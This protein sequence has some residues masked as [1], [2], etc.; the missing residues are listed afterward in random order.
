MRL[1]RFKDDEF[2]VTTVTT[3]EEVKQVLNAGF[4]Y[5]TQKDGVM[6]LNPPKDLVK[7]SGILNAKL[8]MISF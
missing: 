3:L 7:K 4:D 8:T 5:I 2:E 6:L 1:F